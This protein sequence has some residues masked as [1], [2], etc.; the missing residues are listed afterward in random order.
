MLAWLAVRWD[1]RLTFGLSRMLCRGFRVHTLHCRGRS[2][3][4]RGSR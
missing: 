3:H 2:D 4:I 1:N